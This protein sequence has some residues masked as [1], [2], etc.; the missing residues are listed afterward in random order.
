MQGQSSNMQGKCMPNYE[1]NINPATPTSQTAA[2]YSL[3]CCTSQNP[4]RHMGSSR[5][6]IGVVVAALHKRLSLSIPIHKCKQSGHSMIRLYLNYLIYLNVLHF[7]A[8]VCSILAPTTQGQASK[9]QGKCMPHYQIHI[10]PVTATSQAATHTHSRATH[11]RFVDRRMG[12]S[13]WPIGMVSCIAQATL[14][15]YSNS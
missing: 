14:L 4:R 5:W 7:W 3:T 10:N 9:R 11:C 2:P 8:L 15:K 12:S 6:P 1:L 13:R